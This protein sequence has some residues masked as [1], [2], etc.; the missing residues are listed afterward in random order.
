[1]SHCPIDVLILKSSAIGGSA[2]VKVVCSSC[3]EQLKYAKEDVNNIGLSVEVEYVTV[4][5]KVMAYGVMNIP[6]IVINDKQCII[7]KLFTFYSHYNVLL[8]LRA[9]DTRIKF[10]TSLST[11]LPS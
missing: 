8:I 5:Q 6:A 2:V 4:L 9:S 3:R 7:Q 10:S 1:M 11:S